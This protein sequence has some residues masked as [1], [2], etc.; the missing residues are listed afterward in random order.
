MAWYVVTGIS[1]DMP[2]PRIVSR[3]SMRDALDR[4]MSQWPGATERSVE[5]VDWL[6]CELCAMGVE[7]PW[8]AV[9]PDGVGGHNVV[10]SACWLDVYEGDW[11]DVPGL[12]ARC[13]VCGEVFDRRD[14][15]LRGGLC[16]YCAAYESDT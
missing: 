1:G 5:R 16:E 12:V 4:H 2:T 11:S 3:E 10:C 7:A 6:P 14:S 9:V 8:A 15:S 13:R